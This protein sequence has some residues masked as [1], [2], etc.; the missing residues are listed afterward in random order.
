MGTVSLLDFVLTGTFGSVTAGTT[1]AA[2]ETAFGKPEA[3]DIPSRK[4]RQPSIWKYGDVEFH[5]LQPAGV[6][7]LIHLDRFS[8]P[9]G[10]PE[11]WGGLHLEPWIVREGLAV[12][13]FVAAVRQLG[14]AYRFRPQPECNQEVVELASGV[15]V[16]FLLLPEPYSPPVGLA[17]LTRSP[18]QQSIPCAKEGAR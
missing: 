6:L 3:T 14:V 18:G 15:K 13:D 9:E 17:W 11:G 7:T 10:K 1:P 16:G 5:F 2:L 12:E 4:Q 8:A